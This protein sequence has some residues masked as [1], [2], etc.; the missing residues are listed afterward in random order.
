MVLLD[1]MVVY[2]PFHSIGLFSVFDTDILRNADIYTGGFGAEYGGRIS[3]VMD[4]TTR[5][6]NKKRFGGKVDASTFGG[7]IL[8]EGPIAN[9]K[10]IQKEVPLSYYQQRI[11]TLKNIQNAL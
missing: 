4:I 8:F 7:K 6:G 2:N 11:H 10:M 3:S 9:K 5:D 1:G